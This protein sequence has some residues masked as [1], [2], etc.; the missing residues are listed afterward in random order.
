VAI[1]QVCFRKQPKKEQIVDE[2]MAMR[3]NKHPNIVNYLDSYLVGEKLW[4]V[5]E[6]IDGGPLSAVIKEVRMAEGL[7]AAVSRE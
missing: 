5:M 4:I 2:L 3:D 1:K 7:M 6:Y